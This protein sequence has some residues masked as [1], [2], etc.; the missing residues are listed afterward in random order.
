MQ[1]WRTESA[2]RRMLIRPRPAL[3]K[4]M[5]NCRGKCLKTKGRYAVSKRHFQ[6]LR[7]KSLVSNDSMRKRSARN[8]KSVTTLK[9]PLLTILLPCQAIRQLVRR[10]EEIKTGHKAKETWCRVTEMRE[11][12][13]N[14][15][16]LAILLV[17]LNK[18]LEIKMKLYRV[19]NLWVPQIIQVVMLKW[20]MVKWSKMTNRISLSIRQHLLMPNP[21][22]SQG[23]KQ[24]GLVLKLEE[25]ECHWWEVDLQEVK[26]HNQ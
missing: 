9:L 23:C 18:C 22:F 21:M 20:T 4:K 13:V 6:I 7:A 25:N 8:C 12:S 3:P 14:W 16:R 26:L 17:V 1:S 19:E 10:Q 24:E 5:W 11:T 15:R 2:K